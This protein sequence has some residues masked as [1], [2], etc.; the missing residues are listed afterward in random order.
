MGKR[1][2]CCG[3]FDY[4]HPGHIS[5]LEQAAALGSELFVVVARDENVERIKGRLPDHNEELRRTKVEEVGV[6]DEVRL[7][8]PGANFFKVVSD[9]AP[10]IIAL[11]YD[12]KTPSGLRDAFPQCEVLILEAHHPEK[13]KSSLYRR[14]KSQN[15]AS[16]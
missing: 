9:I 16:K 5:F 13:Y 12:Q 14:V 11:G 4:L 10:D 7:G 1:V 2:L 6:A 15:P 3:T 8:Y